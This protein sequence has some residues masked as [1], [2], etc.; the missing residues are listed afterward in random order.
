MHVCM[1][2]CVFAGRVLDVAASKDGLLVCSVSD[3]RSLKVFDVINFGKLTRLHIRI[4]MY[5]EPSETA[6]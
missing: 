4:S 6:A 1:Y 3:D 2:V 5:L